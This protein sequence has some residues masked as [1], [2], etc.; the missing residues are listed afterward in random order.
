MDASDEGPKGTGPESRPSSS[1]VG[2]SVG[3]AHRQSSCVTPTAKAA[4]RSATPPWRRNGAA[5]TSLRNTAAIYEI[6]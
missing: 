4:A 2:G 6:L 3:R 5:Y 1:A